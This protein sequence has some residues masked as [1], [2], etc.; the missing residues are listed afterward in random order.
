LEVQT[1]KIWGYI[2]L[3]YLW[4]NLKGCRCD[5]ICVYGP[6]HEDLK[7]NFPVELAMFCICVDV[8]YIVGGDFNILRHVSEKNKP[9]VLTHSFQI[10]K[11]V[12]HF[13]VL[14]K[15]S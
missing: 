8:N 4:D 12:I 1:V 14:E 6:A 15:F 3:L 7:D 2:I 9:N 11:T 10:F 13:W 5:F